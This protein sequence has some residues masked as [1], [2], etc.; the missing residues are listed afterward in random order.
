MCLFLFR[1]L[2]NNEPVIIDIG[3]G[4]SYNVKISNYC[5]VCN[6]F[7]SEIVFN[8]YTY[9]IVFV[10]LWYCLLGDNWNVSHSI[11]R[12]NILIPS[13]VICNGF[14]ICFSNSIIKWLQFAAIP[15][16]WC[17]CNEIVIVILFC[18]YEIS[19][20]NRHVK[21]L[22]SFDFTLTKKQL[23]WGWCWVV[24]VQKFHPPEFFI[25][26]IILVMIW[27]VIFVLIWIII[28]IMI[29]ILFLLLTFCCGGGAHSRWRGGACGSSESVTELFRLLALFLGK[30]QQP[31]FICNAFRESLLVVNISHYSEGFH[32]QRIAFSLQDHP[33]FLQVFLFSHVVKAS[34]FSQ[35][36]DCLKRFCRKCRCFKKLHCFENLLHVLLMFYETILFSGGNVL[37]I[38]L[39]KFCKCFAKVL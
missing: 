17:F 38:V 26:D 3:N 8:I 16:M 22:N 31:S 36:V 21:E 32:R 6:L 29:W 20:R 30:Y 7:L 9:T 39:R 35:N 18:W 33:L 24:V 1:L 19:W 2:S 13:C 4:V 14:Y 12:P 23:C 11:A 37:Q 28:V 34:R 10:S 15:C 27:I 5:N 25:F